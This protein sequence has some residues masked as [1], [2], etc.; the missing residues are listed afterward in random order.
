MNVPCPFVSR[1]RG[2]APATRARDRA[3][4]RACPPHRDPRPAR[5][6]CRSGQRRRPA[7]CTR[8]P[9][10]HRSRGSVDAGHRVRVAGGIVVAGPG[11]RREGRLTCDGDGECHDEG[12]QPGDVFPRSR[13]SS[14]TPS[15]IERPARRPHRAGRDHD[16][17]SAGGPQQLEHPIRPPFAWSVPGGRAV[18]GTATSASRRSLALRPRLSTGLPVQA[19]AAIWRDRHLWPGP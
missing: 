2:S 18:C 7:R 19:V 9:T 15:V 8:P 6:P 3:R 13:R 10:S 5:S 4:R 12:M 17:M 16:S 11:R 1:L 14:Q